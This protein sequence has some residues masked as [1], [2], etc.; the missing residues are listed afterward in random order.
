MSL[1]GALVVHDDGLA[2]RAF[3]AYAQA[4][5][6][7]GPTGSTLVGTG[8]WTALVQLSDTQFV[9]YSA[10][11]NATAPLNLNQP[12]VLAHVEDDVAYVAVQG[13]SGSLW[14]IHG[15]SAQTGQWR[16][17]TL[18]DPEF[19][20]AA[21]IQSS[22]FVIGVQGS[23]S[24]ATDRLHGFGARIGEWETFDGLYCSQVGIDGNTILY[25]RDVPGSPFVGAIA[26]S[27]V[28]NLW[29]EYGI[30]NEDLPLRLDH[31][32]AMCFG[33]NPPVPIGYSAYTGAWV[34]SDVSQADSYGEPLLGDDLV[35]VPR[36]VSGGPFLEFEGHEA[37]GAR[38]GND[39][40][41]SGGLASAV[42]LIAMGE[43]QVLVAN[44]LT[45]TVSGFSG[46]CGGT[47]LSTS[48]TGTLDVAVSGDHVALIG[49]S[50]LDVQA[51][52]GVLHAF[53]PTLSLASSGFVEYG[54]GRSI[55]W[56]IQNDDAFVCAGRHGAFQHV[57]R[58][59]GISYNTTRTG[60]LFVQQ[61]C[62]GV[63]GLYEV[64]RFCE[65]S[66]LVHG[67][68][69]PSLT[70]DCMER[71]YASGGNAL[72]AYSDVTERLFGYSV[73][74]DAFDA[75]PLTVTLT[76]SL[77][78]LAECDENAGYVIDGD[79]LHAYGAFSDSG[80]FYAYPN[81]TE[82]ARTSCAAGGCAHAD[83]PVVS[84]TV[85]Q[86]IQG[87]P[88]DLAVTLLTLVRLAPPL[89]VPGVSGPLHLDL[90]SPLASIALVG[91]VGPEGLVR[92]DWTVPSAGAVCVP[93][94]MQ[95]ALI[96]SLGGV[97]LTGPEPAASRLY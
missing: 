58:T 46:T 20:P 75:L 1:E 70:M 38:P 48:F 65:R 21:D 77:A 88:G 87:D 45:S 42:S 37:F 10:R 18:N 79:T 47:W 78:S 97:R 90:A 11:L 2:L 36:E 91:A 19:V 32:V 40:E 68:P 6:E 30:G 51:Y 53:S 9:A 81:G 82:F 31:N 73:Q 85:P 33:V 76:A 60:S 94:W 26:F 43:S 8:D 22:R 61:Q 24:E 93:V 49:D 27:G 66:D 4:F 83:E 56:V 44:T 5:T 7:I 34:E 15:Y 12:A 3:S 72:L 54:A 13:A 28:L 29:R 71:V 64:E 39:W 63:A 17:L 92:G 23:T 16:P 86:A 55:V 62:S 52:S 35:V 95:G 84:S 80:D 50:N 74:R 41:V 59:S 14:R 57:D 25:R 89:S 69:D 67:G 96:D